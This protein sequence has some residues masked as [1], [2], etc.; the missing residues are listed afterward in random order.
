MN[1]EYFAE[2]H[3]LIEK[4][5]SFER[6]GREEEAL[7]LYLE[8]HEKFFPN[9]SDLFERPAILLEKRKRFDEAIRICEKAIKLIGEGKIT[10]VK[11]NFERRILRIKSRSD[12]DGAFKQGSAKSEKEKKSAR[13]SFFSR[14][15]KNEN[16]HKKDDVDLPRKEVVLKEIVK[17]TPIKKEIEDMPKERVRLQPRKIEPTPPPEKPV[18]AD[19]AVK[20]KTW[21][22]EKPIAPEKT[23]ESIKTVELEKTIVPD[24]SVELETSVELE[25]TKDP[26]EPIGIIQP[27]EPQILK[28]E[29][30]SLPPNES[31]KKKHIRFKFPKF[32]FGLPKLEDL[33]EMLHEI[34]SFKWSDMKFFIFDL[35]EIKKGKF[36]L[37][38]PSKSEWMAMGIVV[39]TIVILAVAIANKPKS[40]FEIAFDTSAFEWSQDITTD[41]SEE[42]KKDLP[43]ITATMIDAA[44]KR[45]KS[46]PGVL[47]AGIMVQENV[48][49]FIVMTTPE[50]DRK[51]AKEASETFIKA[52][53]SAA[54]AENKDLRGPGPIGY[55]ELF[56][57]YALLVVAGENY[58]NL[59]IKGSKNPKA[60]GIY[61]RN[62]EQ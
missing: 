31:F 38:K 40:Q 58:D 59:L 20:E 22:Y 48:V 44:V 54:A 36:K 34:R 4:A 61:W 60:P 12:Y 10:G 39:G 37:R 7:K 49:G 41:I 43:P 5:K 32:H 9:T 55:G 16:S 25:K 21:E 52:L 18:L 29:L 19:T 35:S 50:A 17:D 27:S 57:Y 6:M 42:N 45:T 30:K 53:A 28:P 1:N 23:R 56:D 26:V 47:M 51:Q 15:K 2:M 46:M 11:D 3:K 14:F 62:E 24:K 33:K 8:I 13:L